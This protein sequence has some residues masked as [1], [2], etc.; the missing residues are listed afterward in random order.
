MVSSCDEV[1][2]LCS[3]ARSPRAP[4]PR[5][6]CGARTAPVSRSCP[7]PSLEP[8][9]VF[10]R[11]S[12]PKPELLCSLPEADTGPAP[13]PGC[14]PEVPVLCPGVASSPRS[15]A[16]PA[17]PKVG[18]DPWV[19]PCHGDT[20]AVAD[21]ALVPF[22]LQGAVGRCWVTRAAMSPLVHV[23]CRSSETLPGSPASSHS[24]SPWQPPLCPS[25][26]IPHH[27]G[28]HPAR[29]T[30]CHPQATGRVQGPRGTGGSGAGHRSSRKAP[31]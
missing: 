27:K 24:R 26:L 29:R 15:P 31:K 1:L 30:L 9:L 25:W 23:P 19:S 2:V 6:R 16:P 5:A 18:S 28:Q 11:L 13:S 20:L 3:L 12:S 22:L 8:S 17:L 10:S 14:A 7:L 21:V 4:V